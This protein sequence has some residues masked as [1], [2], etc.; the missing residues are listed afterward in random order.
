[1]SIQE[2]V[3]LERDIER[4]NR[5]LEKAKAALRRFDE[6]CGHEW[7]DPVRD[8]IYR[9]AYTTPGD[10]P[11]TMGIDWQGPVHVPAETTKRWK[12]TCLRCGKVEHTTNFKKKKVASFKP[13]F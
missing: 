7:S 13:Q 9:A 4:K 2:R 8:D 6:E 3:S 10:P 5:E 11:G 1:M 12:R